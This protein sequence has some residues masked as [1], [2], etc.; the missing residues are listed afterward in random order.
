MV[1]QAANVAHVGRRRALW[2]SSKAKDAGEDRLTLNC[3]LLFI[4]WLMIR[5]RRRTNLVQG[6]RLVPG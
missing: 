6:F 1:L 3:V 5:Q 4:Y 2:Q